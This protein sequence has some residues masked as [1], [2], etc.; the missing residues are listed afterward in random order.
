MVADPI[1]SA[2][3]APADWRT[4]LTDDLKAD[5]V[6]S[7]WAEK[8]SEKDIPSLVKSYAHLSKRMGGAI[9]LPGK[10][11]KPEEVA[12]LKAKLYESGVLTAPPASPQDYGL[13]KPASLPDGMQWSDELAGK[14][15]TAMHKHG[16]PKA[17]LADLMPLYNEAVMGAT[18]SL[19]VNREETLAALRTEHGDKYEERVAAV[20]R[21]SDWIFQS[22]EEVEFAKAN[23]L[24]EHPRFLGPMLRVASLA[25]QDSSF[26]ESLPHSVGTKTEEEA[27]AEYSKIM[28]DPTH[29]MHEGYLRRDAKVEQYVNDLYKAIDRKKE[30]E[31]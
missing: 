16:I 27:R 12:A 8:A 6:V 23:G 9:N 29:P 15:A 18:T 11:A 1:T 3:P 24:L 22:D 4:H 31:V 28:G 10:D 30:V 25:M 17:A 7:S 2:A 14:F 21:L 5:P 19:K 26:M 13:I 20:E